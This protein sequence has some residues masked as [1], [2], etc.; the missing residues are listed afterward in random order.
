MSNGISLASLMSISDK[1]RNLNQTL[2][3]ESEVRI[4]SEE[5][6]KPLLETLGWVFE[7]IWETSKQ[8]WGSPY[9]TY[10]ARKDFYSGRIGG[11]PQFIAAS[12]TNNMS[13]SSVSKLIEYAYN[14]EA[15]WVLSVSPVS[16]RLFHTYENTLKSDLKISPYWELDFD[17]LP[18]FGDEVSNLLSASAVSAGTLGTIDRDVRE[19][20]RVAL[21]VTRKLFDS[22]RYWRGEMIEKLYKN[23]FKHGDL[24]EIDRQV[25]HLLNQIVFIRVAEDRRFGENPYLD[26]LLNKWLESG[27]KSGAFSSQLRILI[28][29]YS[30]RYKVELFNEMEL[31]KEEYLED[32]IA[33]MIKSLHSPGFPTVKYDFSV[34]D[35][36][37]LGTM[38]EQYLKLQPR[39]ATGVFT[40]QARLLNDVPTTELSSSDRALGIHYTPTYIV[41]YIVG[42]SMRRWNLNGNMNKQP[43]IL[44]MACGSGSFLLA[45]YRW[46]LK[47]EENSKGR[48]LSTQE[49]QELLTR[50]IWGV[51]KDPKAVEICKL[52]LW[53]YALEAR[54]SLPNLD[55]NVKVG[56]S[57]LDSTII[58]GDEEQKAFTNPDNIDIKAIMWN[59]DFPEV[60]CQGGWDIIVG[61]P[62]YI[63]IQ[64]IQGEEKQ[65]YL[66]QFELLKGNF[67]VSL[68]FIE[69]AFKLLNNSGITGFIIANSL[70]RANFAS[71]IRGSII[72]N[73]S[74]H[75]ILDFGDQRVFE[76]TGAYTCIV[77]VG[78]K[79]SVNPRMGVV[80]RLSQC[81]AAQ[82]TRWELEDAY[83]DTLVSGNINLS[84]LGEAPWVL[85]PD[86]EYQLRRKL[87]GTGSPLEKYVRIFQ[88]FKTGKD[89]AFIFQSFKDQHE[90][91]IIEVV[92][93]HGKQIE[94]EK[95]ACFLLLKSGDIQRFHIKRSSHWIL[96]P[97]SDGRLLAEEELAEKFP[98]AWEYLNL[99]NTKKEL[100]ERKQVKD[101]KARWY[102]YSFPKSMTLYSKP[103]L[104][105]PDIAPQAS[106]AYDENGLYSFTGGTAGGYGLSLI[107]RNISY[108][109]LLGLLNSQLIDWY[110][111]A[112]SAQFHGGYY[113]YEK[114][115]IKDAPIISLEHQSSRRISDF[116]SIVQM[117]NRT[118]EESSEKR[119]TGQEYRD[120]ANIIRKL[121]GELNE[122]VMEL[123][124]LTQ[125]EKELVRQSPYW[126]K[127]NLLRGE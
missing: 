121:E 39:I 29:G 11:Q 13:T 7:D 85:V 88:G 86:R 76:G 101:Q 63:R 108:E 104:L 102:A 93:S 123:Y 120:V 55:D 60:M 25:N 70:I 43:R 107:G 90:E 126:R 59:R 100:Y 110:V 68:A 1:A 46:L 47:Q 15:S 37:I 79:K 10:D 6:L 66:K 32:L 36:D 61:N 28:R 35:V 124:G 87:E 119:K 51:D 21:P 113:S 64:K 54:Q 78:N 98:L 52:N 8:S 57:L 81:P 62:P 17:L 49:R 106:F 9:L 2:S 96:F 45:S 99:E 117:L 71:L 80:L 97:Y 127:A 42:S 33:Q 31:L 115:F 40:K 3:T 56:D 27:K 89:S 73:E 5:I 53:I 67:D 16:L 103:K 44:D 23:N 82:L 75:G 72:Q 116:I 125:D 114:R 41:D 65:F 92:T 14:K 112:I 94:I 83:D 50:F 26:E 118:Y 34:I 122:S 4:I 109:L 22:L 24:E 84:R 30:E 38:Y 58:K 91:K 19:T 105:T 48:S 18:K 12:F 77:F 69:I 74:L 20:R 95:E 111:Q